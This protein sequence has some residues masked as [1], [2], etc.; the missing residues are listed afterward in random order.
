MAVTTMHMIAKIPNAA[1]SLADS[2][3][4]PTGIP[5]TDL[6]PLGGSRLVCPVGGGGNRKR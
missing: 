6:L 5:Y 4:W 2:A 3:V 1:P